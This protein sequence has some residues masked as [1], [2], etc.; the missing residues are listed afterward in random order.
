MTKRNNSDL[1][2]Q[3]VDVSSGSLLSYSVLLYVR[4]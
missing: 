3:I 2:G 4:N 1:D